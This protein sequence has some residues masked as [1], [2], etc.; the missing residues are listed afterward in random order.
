MRGRIA[1]RIAI[2]PYFP[3][4]LVVLIVNDHVLKAAYPGWLTGKASDFAG[5]IVFPLMILSAIDLLTPIPARRARMVAIAVF[6][7]TGAVFAAIQ[8]HQG[9]ADV[10]RVVLGYLQFPFRAAFG[11]TRAVAVRH[12]ADPSDLLGL[13][14]L[15]LSWMVFRG[16]SKSVDHGQIESIPAASD[17]ATTIER[18]YTQ[19][20]V[21]V[22]DSR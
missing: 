14:A 6:V 9:S 3:A 8:L 2:N 22:G 18:G 7:A 20:G 16:A 19:H 1:Y 15:G 11:A 21:S 17:R 10:Y 4:A 12:T 5:L 13:A